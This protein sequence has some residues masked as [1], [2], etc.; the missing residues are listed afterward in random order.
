MYFFDWDE[1][2]NAIN[3]VKHGISFEEASTVFFDERA[4]LFDDPDHKS[5]TFNR[6]K[7]NDEFISY[8]LTYDDYG[9]MVKCVMPAN[10]EKANKTLT[11]LYEYDTNV[12]THS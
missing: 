8:E 6:Y 7:N 11:Y 12:F 3:I 9:N 4:L 1:N 10:D 2:K 5:A